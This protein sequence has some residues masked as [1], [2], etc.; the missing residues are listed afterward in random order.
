MTERRPGGGN[1]FYGLWIVGG[2]FVLLFLFAGA[3]F[4]SFS[5]FIK[6]LE[7]DFGWGRS[8]I[9]LAMSIYMIVQGLVGPLVGQ[10]TQ[11]YG[12][13]KVM[14][15]FSLF[16]GAAFILVSFTESL[17]FFYMSYILLSIGTA[18]IG[19]IPVSSLLTRWFVRRRGTAT[20]FA[21]LGISLGGLVMAPVVGLIIANFGWR[22]SFVVLGV[23]VWVLALPVTLFV[24]KPSPAELGLMADGDDPGAAQDS[25]SSPVRGNSPS[26][27]VNEGWP[28]QAALRT[29]EFFWIAITFLLAP[30]A[31]MGMLQHQVPLVVEAGISETLAATALG[32]TAG[33]GGLGK[34]S[35]GRISEVVPFRYALM[36]CFGL[37]AFGVLVLFTA[38][39]AAMVWAYVVIFGF[40]MG[41][42][43]VLV[44]LTV[45]HFFGLASFGVI[46]GSLS[47]ILAVGNASGALLS[48]LIYDFLGSYDSAMMMYMGLY[49]AAIFS[50]F[51]AGK[52]RLYAP[53]PTETVRS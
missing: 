37:Q 6:P 20:G 23:L 53:V 19:I 24:I 45:A 51:L 33:L 14:T 26:A 8:A 42:V 22:V 16:S 50:I 39:T 4:Y 28:L 27:V 32:L 17:W 15:L 2:C 3:G 25:L 35:F 36:L 13:K 49:V 46:M 34:L 52:P 11:T 41:G 31:Q 38:K 47:L 48:G 10:A 44:P 29:R 12:P 30:L 7:N 18:G 21:M 40:A 1:T 9:S 5:I 43:V